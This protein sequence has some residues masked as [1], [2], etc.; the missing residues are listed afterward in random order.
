M[1]FDSYSNFTKNRLIPYNTTYHTTG[2]FYHVALSTGKCHPWNKCFLYRLENQYMS[3]IWFIDG[4]LKSQTTY[5]FAIWMRYNVLLQCYCLLILRICELIW[6]MFKS[7]VTRIFWLEYNFLIN[8]MCHRPSWFLAK[9]HES[10]R[11]VYPHIY[12]IFIKTYISVLIKYHHLQ[13]Y[14]Y[15][16]SGNPSSL[17]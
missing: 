12:F 1:S 9:Q 13:Y 3:R 5:I 15:T 14:S 17:L 7:F 11:Y 6:W 4:K 16:Q 10:L 8:N 2:E